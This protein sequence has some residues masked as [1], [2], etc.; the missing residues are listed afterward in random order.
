MDGWEDRKMWMGT[1]HISEAETNRLGNTLT[2]R[3]K[4]KRN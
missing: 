1:R 2:L 3:D 4:R